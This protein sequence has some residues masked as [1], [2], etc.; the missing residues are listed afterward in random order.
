MFSSL[1]TVFNKLPFFPNIFA[2][3]NEKKTPQ[4]L[5]QALAQRRG[6]RPGRRGGRRLRP[7]GLRRDA[8]DR[9]AA[10]GRRVAW[11]LVSDFFGVKG[12][13]LSDFFLTFMRKKR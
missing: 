6:G 12:Q 10:G 5:H 8:K 9:A 13:G 2:T 3:K 4:D 1:Q 7:G 11:T